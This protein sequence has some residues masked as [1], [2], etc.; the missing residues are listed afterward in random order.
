[1]ATKVSNCSLGI[2]IE[3]PFVQH[4]YLF[5]T[6]ADNEFLIFIDTKNNLKI[7]VRE[8]ITETNFNGRKVKHKPELLDFANLAFP[9][10]TD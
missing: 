10:P 9:P 5:F 2:A 3:S 7:I 1:M 6:S 8:L 4:P